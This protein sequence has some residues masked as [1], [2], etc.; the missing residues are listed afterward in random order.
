MRF[1]FKKL[2][3]KKNKNQRG[4]TAVEFAIVIMIFILIVFGIIEFGLLMYN[5][6]VVTNAGREG[7]RTSIVYKSGLEEEQTK[8]IVENYGKQYIVSFGDKIFDV[9][10]FTS[11][12]EK[13]QEEENDQENGHEEDNL[14]I[15]VN[16]GDYLHITVDYQYDFLLL[17]FNKELSSTTT[18]RCE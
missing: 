17:P 7:A 13:D 15:C 5:Q 1:I 14:N 4:A 10:V 11:I 2:I 16:S 18:M 3:L 8:E 9:K 12:N 6:H